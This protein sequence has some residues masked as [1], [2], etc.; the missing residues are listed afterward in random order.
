MPI[1]ATLYDS[2]P[3]GGISIRR[4]AATLL[5]GSTG[6]G[7]KARSVFR[8]EGFDTRR[9]SDVCADGASDVVRRTVMLCGFA[10]K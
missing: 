8:L 5:P 6:Q 10:A 3:A 7:E 2:P 4:G 9:E 1:Y